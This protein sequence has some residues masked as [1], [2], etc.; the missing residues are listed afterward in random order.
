MSAAWSH[1]TGDLSATG[2][3]VATGKVEKLCVCTSPAEGGGCLCRRRSHEGSPLNCSPV[4][5]S[6]SLLADWRAVLGQL[7]H[8]SLDRGDFGALS[9]RTSGTVSGRMIGKEGR[10]RKN[11]SPI[12]TI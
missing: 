11:N 6:A 4:L 10:G 12:G 7:Q 5:T 1:D 3:L 8:V 2:R 9:D